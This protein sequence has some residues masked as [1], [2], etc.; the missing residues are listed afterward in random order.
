[1]RTLGIDNS[2]SVSTAVGSVGSVD[3]ADA[4]RGAGSSTA[5]DEGDSLTIS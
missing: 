2:S 4:P 1:M 3:E 5:V